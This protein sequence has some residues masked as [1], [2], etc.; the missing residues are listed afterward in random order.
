MVQHVEAVEDPIFDSLVELPDLVALDA[1]LAAA[2]E[3]QLRSTA[4]WLL[5]H[6]AALREH[7]PGD[8]FDLY[9]MR[10]WVE[11]VI[12]AATAAPAEAAAT[13]VWDKWWS[14]RDDELEFLHRALSRRPRPWAA[15]FVPAAARI[16]VGRGE[17]GATTC[18]VFL[19]VDSLVR[20]HDLPV[21]DGDAFLHGW[22]RHGSQAARYLPELL[23]PLL[24]SSHLRHRPDFPAT[25]DNGLAA[26]D[27]TRAGAVA[28]ALEGLAVPIRPTAQRVLADILVGLVLTPEELAGRLPL[29]QGSLATAHGSLTAVLLPAALS[30]TTEVADLDEIASVIAGRAEK[31]QRS[32]LLKTLQTR[33]FRERL[34]DAAILSALAHLESC[35]DAS[36]RERVARFRREIGPGNGPTDP[37]EAES[38][39]AASE[40]NYAGLWAPM[41]R[42]PRSA[43]ESLQLPTQLTVGRM[44]RLLGDWWVI[45]HMEQ[46]AYV[47]RIGHAAL[48]ECFVRIAADSTTFR[49]W[50]PSHD[51]DIWQRSHPVPG[52]ISCWLR[53]DLDHGTIYDTQIP[54]TFYGNAVFRW[55]PREHLINAAAREALWRAGRV[56]TVL[57]TPSHVDGTIELGE[58]LRRIATGRVLTYTPNDLA[59]ALLRLRPV[60]PADRARVEDLGDLTLSADPLCW[61]EH[62][63][64][65][66]QPTAAPPDGIDLI[67]RWVGDGGLRPGDAQW[68]LI[69][70]LGPGGNIQWD[71]GEQTPLPTSV[72]EDLFI[73]PAALTDNTSRRAAITVVPSWPDLAAASSPSGWNDD[74]S[75]SILLK[76][77]GPMGTPIH[78][79]V[80]MPLSFAPDL[81]HLAVNGLL[82]LVRRDVLSTTHLQQ[83]VRIL[84]DGGHLSFVRLAHGLE[85][86]F[87]AGALADLWAAALAI[88]A[89]ASA[90]RP[91]PTGLPDLLRLLAAYRPAVPDF[92]LPAEITELAA[93]RDNSK[94]RAEAR[95]LIAAQ[96]AS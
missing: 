55:S 82:E 70:E 27:I 79:A 68:D 2:D 47:V 45:S 11:A 49:T 9:R 95:A 86:A 37:T 60:S 18:L 13:L 87:V 43:P 24:S 62:T 66:G 92:V 14:T 39:Q 96:G 72:L 83:A 69:D 80:L 16:K 46:G 58:L 21:P 90:R 65:R 5:A 48:L 89:E 38:M 81:R 44:R 1:W 22:A 32:T 56:A 53:G 94:S 67:R 33:V 88:T 35:D 84:H 50:L 40:P 30:L 19:L 63:R 91:L 15:A 64:E 36:L 29:L 4:A 59:L 31:R 26:G 3:K 57:S 78:A 8:A 85:Q 23:A 10:M 34:G 28:A 75:E 42:E 25:I 61:A 93:A 71:W 20:Q 17:E 12:V 73:D 54:A 51:D 7:P 6:K 52:A 76:G 77:P 74:Q 41:R